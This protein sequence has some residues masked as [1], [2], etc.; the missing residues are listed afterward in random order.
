MWRSAVGVKQGST[1][2]VPAERLWWLAVSFFYY[3]TE[4]AGLVQQVAGN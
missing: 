1:L 4:R 2:L 3:K